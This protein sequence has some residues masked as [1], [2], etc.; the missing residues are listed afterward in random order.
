VQT[1]PQQTA[2]Q[3]QPLQSPMQKLVRQVQP[4]QLPPGVQYLQHQHRS[5]SATHYAPV[6]SHPHS[7]Q[8]QPQQIAVQQQPLQSPMQQFVGQ[9][10]PQQS[11][12][13]Q[14][15]T[16]QQQYLQ[17][18]FVDQQRAPSQPH[19]QQTRSYQT[20]PQPQ[21]QISYTQPVTPQSTYA[22]QAIHH[23]QNNYYQQHTFPPPPPPP[24][25]QTNSHAGSTSSASHHS[26]AP[27][28]TSSTFKSPASLSSDSSKFSAQ[29]SISS[30]YTK[31]KPT[32][33]KVGSA[34]GKGY[35]RTSKF[36]TSSKGKKVMAGT[37]GLLVAG[38][39]GAEVGDM[40]G[41]AGGADAL[42]GG[43]G[44]G[45]ALAG[46][47]GY[48]STDMAASQAYYDQVEQGQMNSLNLIDDTQYELVPDV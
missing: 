42:A 26:Y 31:S 7:V 46:G 39:I 33:E 24:P 35:K 5:A 16:G 18:Q 40:L 28:P 4:Q 36:L 3:Q 6:V 15:F 25:I 17:Q 19:Q 11:P 32:A 1:L 23:P 30:F 29:A 44:G 12:Q 37:A 21:P 38:F 41:G 9:V 47:G 10:Q 48:D 13:Q 8:T 14:Q 45:D 34:L 27:P 43:G 22:P 20:Y 2:A